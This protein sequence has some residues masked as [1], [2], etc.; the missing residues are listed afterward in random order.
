ML[1]ILVSVSIVVLDQ[2]LKFAIANALE[3][4][5]SVPVIKNIFH[6]T[7]VQNTGAAFGILKNQAVLF[8]AISIIAILLV[9]YYLPKLGKKD[10]FAKVSFALILGG[11][12]GN[13]IDRLR[14]GYVIDFI[15]FRIWPV[16]NVADSALTIGVLLLA[17]ELLRKKKYASDTV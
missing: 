9:L 14:F 8:I 16:F 4:G 11:A 2:I 12:A 6:I 7:L 1:L 3:P 10:K 15:D 13:L 5:Q 17:I